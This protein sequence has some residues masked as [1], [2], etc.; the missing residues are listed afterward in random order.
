LL[1][2]VTVTI[3]LY[4]N[5]FPNLLFNLNLSKAAGLKHG[6]PKDLLNEIVPLS[7]II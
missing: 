3:A 2:C 4:V 5:I 1:A 6:L 7:T